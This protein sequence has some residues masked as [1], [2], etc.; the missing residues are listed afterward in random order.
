MRYVMIVSQVIVAL[1]LLN[2]WLVRRNKSTPYRGGAATNMREE[3]AAYGLPAWFE[4][5]VGALKIGIAIALL[6]GIWMPVVVGPAAG[7][8]C[9]LMLGA[10]TMHMRVGDPASRYVPALS[11]LLLAVVLVYGSLN[12]WSATA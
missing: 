3:F 4:V 2:V 5:F 6:A 10:L 7:L 1:G 11:M 9:V 12:H 8:L